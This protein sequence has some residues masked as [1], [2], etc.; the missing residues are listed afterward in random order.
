MLPVMP[1]WEDRDISA[2]EHERPFATYGW[3]PPL[4]PWCGHWLRP[5]DMRPLGLPIKAAT[6]CPFYHGMLAFGQKKWV[7]LRPPRVERGSDGFWHSSLTV[8]QLVDMAC[9]F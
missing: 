9:S 3:N 2:I 6:A 4:C 8:G 7:D 1:P 5:M